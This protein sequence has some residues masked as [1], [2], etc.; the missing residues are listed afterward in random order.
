VTTVIGIAQAVALL[1]RN[2]KW[3]RT[4]CLWAVCSWTFAAIIWAAT[5]RRAVISN[6]F[7]PIYLSFV[8]AG[9]I[10][11]IRLGRFKPT[12]R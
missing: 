7:L 3:R 8:L 1:K 6:P 2:R 11:Y 5:T 10:R 4:T 9:T 12:M